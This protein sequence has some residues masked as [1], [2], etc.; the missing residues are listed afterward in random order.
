MK[1]RTI[2][3]L[4]AIS[5]GAGTVGCSP[6]S[7]GGIHESDKVDLNSSGVTTVRSPNKQQ[8]DL[9]VYGT[10]QR[11]SDRFPQEVEGKGNYIIQVFV[12]PK[13]SEKWFAQ[14]VNYFDDEWRAHIFLGGI[15]GDYPKQGDE[16][17]VVAL[18]ST[19]RF[20]DRVQYSSLPDGPDVH[21]VSEKKYLIVDFSSRPV[22]ESKQPT[23]NNR[24]GHQEP[25]EDEDGTGEEQKSGP[26]MLVLI[27]LVCAFIIG[28]VLVVM[29]IK[30]K[31]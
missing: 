8:F 29:L 4:I 7:G 25:D 1:S 23:E 22:V 2:N 3:T 30:L 26:P 12:W 14:K 19:T 5:I 15:G 16:F 10:V 31:K 11:G 17:Y 24:P 18:A 20:S 6:T 9:H 21:Q 28:G 27:V 13:K